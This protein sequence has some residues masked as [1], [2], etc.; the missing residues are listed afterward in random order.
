M[1]R[2]A[3]AQMDFRGS[4]RSTN[5]VQ[6]KC[7]TT[8]GTQGPRLLAIRRESHCSLTQIGWPEP[9]SGRMESWWVGGRAPTPPSWRSR[10]H[11]R[12]PTNPAILT[13]EWP[14]S[15]PQVVRSPHACG[16]N[17]ENHPCHRPSPCLALDG[18][19]KL[20]IRCAVLLCPCQTCD[21]TLPLTEQAFE[22]WDRDLALCL[23]NNQELARNPETNKKPVEV[24]S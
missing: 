16:A 15:R 4:S 24:V 11:G 19:V 12:R 17:R 7:V 21:N 14:V 2:A 3:C 10:A 6:R 1:G 22:V 20:D 8:G 13:H 23:G 18:I 5:G 9:E